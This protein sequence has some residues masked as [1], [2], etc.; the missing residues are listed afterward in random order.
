[1]N[2]RIGAK[3][4]G[5]L[6]ALQLRVLANTGAYDCDG[7]HIPHYAL[8]GGIGP[9]RWPVVDAEAQ[10]VF[11]NGPKAGQMRGFGTPQGT[12]A[13][14][15]ALDEAAQQ[16]GIDPLELRLR[17]ALESDEDTAFG[18]P[19]GETLA[20]RQCLETAAPYYHSALETAHRLDQACS[21]G[22]WR[23]GV[24]LAGMW[25]RFGKSP[26]IDCPAHAELGRDGAVTFFF[27]APDYGQGTETVL[28]Q[29]A[30]DA[31]GWPVDRIRTVNADTALT[32]DSGV[33]GASRST[34]WVGGAVANAAKALRSV[35]LDVAS[36]M[37][38]SHPNKL[39]LDPIGITQHA[40]GNTVTLPQVA[41]EMDR[42]GLS[43]KVKG[44]FQPEYSLPPTDGDHRTYLPFFVSGV[45]IAEVS[46]NVETGETNVHR[47][48]G[49]HDVGRVIN[50][51][52]AEGQVEGAILMSLGSALME[53][54][55]PGTSTGFSDYY[56][57]TLRSAPEIEVV[58][59]E[60][61]SRWGPLGAKGLA[62]GAVLPTAPAILNAVSH[63]V[64]G[65]VRELP[66][67]PERV[68]NAIRA[69]TRA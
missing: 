50:P 29:L 47:V 44:V 65:R 46:V 22:I 6:T 41:A 10:V 4:D 23:R 62:E 39:K 68:L 21:E 67:T 27:S 31:L 18:Y 20:Y 1:V 66:A 60:V 9:Y 57:P 59:V 51:Q 12:F 26:P 3:A 63:A 56:L 15:C 38:D 55:L 28:A 37:L 43:R 54:Y 64:G 7:Y 40:R 2:L 33:Q 8:V 36:E 69:G 24:G 42:I 16:L 30:A 52:G 35:I 11:T 58:F 48:V 49:V 19:A 53:E 34:Y 45:H 13:L 32:P 14:E 17:N 25:Y 61:P 5:R